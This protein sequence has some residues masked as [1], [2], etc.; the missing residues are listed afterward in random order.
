VVVNPN[1]PTGHFVRQ[2]ELAELTAFGLPIIS[3]EVFR[4]YALQPAA[5]SMLTLQDAE[6]APVF[7]LNGLSKTVGLPQMKLAWMIAKCPAEALERLEIIADTY[8]SVG[9]PVQC[10]L[11]SL[12]EL[13]GPVQHQ[14]MERLR[15]NLAILRESGLRML[16]IEAGW[17]AI[18]AKEEGSELRLLREHDVLVQPGYFYDFESSG[19]IVLSLLTATEIFQEGVRRLRL[20]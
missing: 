10:A 20:G 17:Y 14:I 9:T 11:P 8:L 7:I 12:L 19:Y 3:D 18:V 13:R 15:G 2:H 6:D 1:N 5:D 16:D 4:D